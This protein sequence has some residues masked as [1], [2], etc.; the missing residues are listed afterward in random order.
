MVQ[1]STLKVN[2]N[3]LILSTFA[4]PFGVAEVVISA[5]SLII[6]CVFGIFANLLTIIT[7]LYSTKLRYIPVL[8]CSWKVGFNQDHLFKSATKRC[9]CT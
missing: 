2:I 5:T 4:P 8:F 9:D 3:L 7:I 1:N 6:L